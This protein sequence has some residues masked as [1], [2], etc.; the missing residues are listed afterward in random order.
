MAMT[1]RARKESRHVPREGQARPWPQRLDRRHA[2]RRRDPTVGRR[3]AVRRLRA[4]VVFGPRVERTGKDL[5]AAHLIEDAI[6]A[7]RHGDE[8]A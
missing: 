7:K 3:K 6:L 8:S 5:L 4:A 2:V 1:A